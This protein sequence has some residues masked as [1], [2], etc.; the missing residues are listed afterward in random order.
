MQEPDRLFLDHGSSPRAQKFLNGDTVVASWDSFSSDDEVTWTA[1][2]LWGT[3]SVT[4]PVELS[5]ADYGL[6]SVPVDALTDGPQ[7]IV[8]GRAAFRSE[9]AAGRYTVPPVS[10]AAWP[11]WIRE[12][13]S[14]TGEGIDHRYRKHPLLRRLVRLRWHCF[15]DRLH[16]RDW[17]FGWGAGSGSRTFRLGAVYL[18]R[19]DLASLALLRIDLHD[20]MFFRVRCHGV[21]VF[22][23]CLVAY[24]NGTFPDGTPVALPLMT[25]PVTALTGLSGV[26]PELLDIPEASEPARTPDTRPRRW[27]RA[28]RD[29]PEDED[30]DA[31]FDR[32]ARW[33][34]DREIL[35]GRGVSALRRTLSGGTVLI[36]PD[37]PDSTGADGV[38]MW[39]LRPEEQGA[40]HLPVSDLE[41]AQVPVAQTDERDCVATDGAERFE[42]LFNAG[43]LCRATPDSTDGWGDW[44]SGNL[45]IREFLVA[46]EQIYRKIRYR[47]FDL[48]GGTFARVQCHGIVRFRGH[49]VAY[50][51]G[52]RDGGP[53]SLPLL[54]VSDGDFAGLNGVPVDR[55]VVPDA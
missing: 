44:L 47:R 38:T 49:V 54:A 14:W 37:L 40:V 13:E 46:D 28:G 34:F 29:Y 8:D 11:R 35:V 10:T 32:D 12:W 53:W 51:N 55:L 18:A 7:R 43:L 52:L 26:P 4:E 6:V 45:R 30:V 23:G 5:G 21:A 19:A 27:Y 2:S 31:L 36:V 1:P 22:R 9:F 39:E 25:V 16:F 20:G 42:D 24:V 50:V 33:H 15:R 41:L 17:R 48:R 3:V